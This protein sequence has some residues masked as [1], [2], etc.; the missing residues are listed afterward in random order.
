MRS[1]HL[2]HGD[3]G[4]SAGLVGVIRRLAERLAAVR[5]DDRTAA[6]LVGS[7]AGAVVL[8]ML[9]LLVVVRLTSNDGPTPAMAAPATT[10]KRAATVT[11]HAA[12]TATPTPSP[13]PSPTP[14]T[15][16]GALFHTLSGL[17]LASP[18]GAQSGT[19]LVQRVCQNAAGPGFQ[20]VV[21]DAGAGT[22]SLIDGA[23]GRCVDVSGGSTENGAAVILWDCTGAPNQ[24]FRIQP[25]PGFGGYVQLVA[26]H[27]GSCLDVANG[28][29]QDSAPIQQWECHSAE[30]EAQ[31]RNQSWRLTT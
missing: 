1:S 17:C 28:S 8:A 18:P 19:R 27:S 29:T 14:T 13:T 21:R 3:P 16:T 4:Q 7:V 10:A 12:P 25:S 30:E 22:Y 11:R 2:R 5:G 9:L 15:P 6:I 31:W 26:A 20:L 23:T 24:Q